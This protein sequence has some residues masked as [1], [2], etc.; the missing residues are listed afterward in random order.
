MIQIGI[1]YI[2]EII[3]LWCMSFGFQDLTGLSSFM[4]SVAE[5][6]K[7]SWVSKPNISLN[8]SAYYLPLSGPSAIP[9]HCPWVKLLNIFKLCN[10]VSVLQIALMSEFFFFFFLFSFR[11]VVLWRKAKHEGISG[12]IHF[13]LEF[14]QAL[15]HSFL[16]NRDNC[17][18]RIPPV[19]KQALQLVVIR[20]RK[21]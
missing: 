8:L 7:P 14:T 20:H 1:L 17:F 18:S 21:N 9:C 12:F 5:L 13:V 16:S 2:C 3:L 10:I 4:T 6:G 11:V 15:S 19:I